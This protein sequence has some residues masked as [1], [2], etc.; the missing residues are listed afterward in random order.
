MTY[1]KDEQFLLNE[2]YGGNAT[3]EFFKDVERLTQGEPLAYV[4]G[5]IPFCGATIHLDSRPL[6]PRVES[7]F[8]L[9]YALSVPDEH[10]KKVLD[11]F[12]GSGAL[13]VAWGKKRPQDTITFSEIDPAHKETIEKNIRENDLQNE[14]D[15]VVSDV[16]KSLTESYDII[17]ANP[18]YVPKDRVLPK[19][20]IEHEPLTAL[21]A[22]SDGLVF[23]K[24]FIEGLTDHIR[25]GGVV[26]LEH[27]ISHAEQIP[28]LF[29]SS[30]DVETHT[31]QYGASRF[32]VAHYIR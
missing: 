24:L 5:N 18:P 17:L 16:W 28:L 29:P 9:E 14:T 8:W 32:T 30:F 3:E 2:K 7:E 22:G 12:A 1:T 6:I 23:I 26:F 20:V 25:N 13:G 15:V 11:I 19:G 27:D 31:D 10:P 21:F 4:I